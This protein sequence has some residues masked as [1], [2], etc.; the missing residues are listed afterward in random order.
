MPNYWAMK[1]FK[2]WAN[3]FQN[4]SEI[5]IDEQGVDQD[6]TTYDIQNLPSILS[7][8]RL[9]RRFDQFCKWAKIGD[10]VIVGV[11]QTTQ[12]N[13]QIIGRITGG[14]EFDSQHNLYRHFRSIEIMKIFNNPIPVEKW[15]QMQRVELV[16]DNDFIDTLVKSI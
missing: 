6:Y 14:Y 8:P 10:Y 13:M 1:T 3:A 4:I 7:N 15:G 9:I 11:G 5:G 12:F 16:D 2:D